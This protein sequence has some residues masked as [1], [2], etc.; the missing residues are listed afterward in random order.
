MRLAVSI[1]LDP[2]PCYYRIHALGPP[3]AELRDV[4]LRRAL[5][6]LAEI[7]AR[8]RVPATWFVVGEDLDP[9]A[10]GAG[11]AEA[12]R[13]LLAE[14]HAAGDELGNHS[15]THP[16]D[17]ARRGAAE[18]AA[19]IGGC[20]E[21][22]RAITG[23][24]IAGFRAPGYDLSAVMLAELARRGYVYDS[25]IFPAPGYY[26]AK[27]AVMAGLRALGRPSGAVMTDPRA[28][29]APTDAYRPSMSAPWR[30]G[31]APLVE[32][33]IAVTPWTRVPAFGTSLLVAPAWV[34]ERLLGA[35]RTRPL[36]NLELHGIDLIDAE[37]DGIPGELVA[38]QPD[39]RVPLAA[40]AAALDA[41]LARLT[42]EREAMTLRAAA[43]VAQREA[44]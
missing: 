36:F 6:R 38:R 25:S 42:A 24:P 9:A 5:P 14:R 17:L 35:M 41:V 8:H 26:A 44:A 15:L 11:S 40:K 19:E 28:L 18:V 30:R 10:V 20:E 2:I 27:A 37:L 31:Q 16:Y 23:R 3:P 12:V 39:L 34:R 1:D 43:S 33:P 13:A 21:R 32:L 4:V 22:L 29:M 7:F